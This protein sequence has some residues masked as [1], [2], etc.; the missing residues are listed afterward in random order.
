MA[1]C[2]T[3]KE[4]LSN[5]LEN[6]LGVIDKSEVQRHLDQCPTC[7][8][9]YRQVQVLTQRLRSTAAIRTSPEFEKN[10]RAK[11]FANPVQS[12]NIFPLRNIFYGLSGAA[13]VAAASFLIVSNLSNTANPEVSNSVHPQVSNPVT[14]NQQVISA[15]LKAQNPMA[16]PDPVVANKPEK[17]DTLKKEPMQ[18]SK[19]QIKLVDQQR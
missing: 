11:I 18:I 19:E 8:Q 12:R 5:H 17:Q 2:D 16:Q 3:I 10:L 15:P 6:T 7:Q 4:M 1:F 14:T 13:A 9:V